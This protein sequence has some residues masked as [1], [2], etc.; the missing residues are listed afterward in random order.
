MSETDETAGSTSGTPAKRDNTDAAALL[1]LN[2]A[3]ES[4]PTELV[5]LTT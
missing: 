5:D 2:D 1:I 3:G 4:E